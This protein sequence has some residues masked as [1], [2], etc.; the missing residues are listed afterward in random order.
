MV[1]LSLGLAATA[2]MVVRADSAALDAYQAALPLFAHSVGPDHVYI[3]AAQ[4][5]VAVAAREAG[6]LEAAL[7]LYTSVDAWYRARVSP[8]GHAGAQ[9]GRVQALVAV[10][11]AT[12]AL[13]ALDN[14]AGKPGRLRTAARPRCVGSVRARPHF[15][16]AG[17]ACR[18]PGPAAPRR[19][20]AAEDRGAGLARGVLRVVF[21]SLFSSAVGVTQRQPN[22]AD[23]VCRHSPSRVEPELRAELEPSSIRDPS[24]KTLARQ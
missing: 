15:V 17:S 24:A 5:Q 14:Q 23:E 6:H 12:E 2:L 8:A 3:T 11:R 10:Q 7:A 20:A 4:L 16:G 1:G 9:F 18:R 22:A 19:A 21:S 13:E